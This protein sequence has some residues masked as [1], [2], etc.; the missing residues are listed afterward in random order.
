M[1]KSSPTTVIGAT[2]RDLTA[3]ML[4]MQLVSLL[5]PLTSC[6]HYSLIQLKD[7]FQNVIVDS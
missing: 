6:L 5:P 4:S 2:A 3:V 7:I 1:S